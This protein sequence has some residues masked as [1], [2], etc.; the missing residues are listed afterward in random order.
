MYRHYGTYRHTP[1]QLYVMLAAVPL[2]RN[3]ELEAHLCN[4]NQRAVRTGRIPSP[5]E[6]FTQIDFC[7][8]LHLFTCDP[9]Y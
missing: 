1:N 6:T 2:T 5:K 9:T 3:K 8:R 4:E 7:V